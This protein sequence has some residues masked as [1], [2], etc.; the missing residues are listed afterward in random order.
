MDNTPTKNI[1][2]DRYGATRS[3]LSFFLPQV[4]SQGYFLPSVLVVDVHPLQGLIHEK[5]IALSSVPAPS[6]TQK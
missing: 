1:K 2:M 4:L 5:L 3:I 6:A